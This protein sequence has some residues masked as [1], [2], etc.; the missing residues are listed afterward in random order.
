V[1]GLFIIIDLLS[2]EMRIAIIVGVLIILASVLAQETD[3]IDFNRCKVV[4]LSSGDISF[5][6]DSGSVMI[7]NNKVYPLIVLH[8]NRIRTSYEIYKVKD[9]LSV[10]SF[11]AS[12]GSVFSFGCNKE[13]KPITASQVT[14]GVMYQYN[15]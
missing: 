9:T 1:E 7:V 3:I 5:N 12:N 13:G 10:I 4:D 2:V 6:T 8:C 14:N 11:Y 15:Y